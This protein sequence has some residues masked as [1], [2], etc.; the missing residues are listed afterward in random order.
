MGKRIR[1][2]FNDVNGNWVIEGDYV[3]AHGVNEGL[4]GT[5][6]RCNDDPS[7]KAFN[8]MTKDGII[9]YFNREW[10]R[11][12]IN[13]QK[14]AKKQGDYT[15]PEAVKNFLSMAVGEQVDQVLK[16]VESA[17]EELVKIIP[18]AVWDDEYY[19]FEV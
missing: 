18:T 12:E 10:T 15:D 19:S 11:K 1:E 16:E 2:N 3:Y 9:Q 5:V 8:V 4:E 17:E 7:V 6:V 13:F 14:W